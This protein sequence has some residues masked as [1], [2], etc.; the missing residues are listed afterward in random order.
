MLTSILLG[1]CVPGTDPSEVQL[2]GC[3]ARVSDIPGSGTILDLSESG[4]TIGGTGQFFIEAGASGTLT[5][6]GTRQGA[7][8][9]L[10]L[11]YDNGLVLPFGATIR[12]GDRFD[13]YPLDAEGRRGATFAEFRHCD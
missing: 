13:A 11:N 1:S 12:N 6:V 7:D 2:T 10:T 9:T 4:T 3:W 8:F 5:V